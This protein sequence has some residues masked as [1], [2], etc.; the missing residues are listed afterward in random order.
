MK[1]DG[2]GR[3]EGQA[4]ISVAEEPIRLNYKGIKDNVRISPEVSEAK[5][6]KQL[7]TMMCNQKYFIKKNIIKL[8]RNVDSLQL[9]C[10][11]FL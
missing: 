7:L 4:F 1:R 11:E 3:K 8:K 5:V 6:L 10:L 2:R 9:P